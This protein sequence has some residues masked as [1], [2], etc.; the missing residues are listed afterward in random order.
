MV[1]LMRVVGSVKKNEVHVISDLS[2]RLWYVLY[3]WI[4]DKQL[5]Y[6]FTKYSLF[7]TFTTIPPVILQGSKQK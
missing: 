3:L 6:L 5:I 7:T 1:G 2:H 4:I